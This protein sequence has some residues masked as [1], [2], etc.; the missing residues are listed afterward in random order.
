MDVIVG[1]IAGNH[2]SDRRDNQTGRMIRVCM[3]K[4][5][6]DQFMPF[7]INYIPFELLCDHQLVRNLARKSRLPDRTEELRGGILAHNLHS[8][9]RCQCSGV[10]ESLKKSADS[11][12]MVSMAMRD[13][14]GCQFLTSSCNPICQSLGLFDRHK[15]IHKHRV[16]LAINEG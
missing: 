9:G 6:G 5:H 12:P 7:Q 15:G 10:W 4:F 13:V 3:T 14:D 11:K 2:E 8:V 16:P 1:G